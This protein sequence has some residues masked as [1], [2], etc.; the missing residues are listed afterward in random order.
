[1]T[2]SDPQGL[3]TI[4]IRV[5]D[6]AGNTTTTTNHSVYIDTIAPAAP[7]FVDAVTLTNQNTYTL[8]VSGEP[9]SILRIHNQENQLNQVN[10]GSDVLG[11]D[12]RLVVELNL[13][14]GQ[15]D[16][17]ATL[18]DEVG[19]VSSA[20]MLS[21]VVDQTPPVVGGLSEVLRYVSTGNVAV[22]FT[23]IDPPPT[24]SQ[25]G[26]TVLLPGAVAP[27]PTGM[28][29]AIA[30]S[31][32]FNNQPMTAVAVEGGVYTYS[33]AVTNSDIQG[34]AS[35]KI[36]ATDAA[37]NT[38]TTT[39]RSVFIDTIAPVAPVVE[40]PLLLTND[41]QYSVGITA[42]IGTK[43]EVFH[44]GVLKQTMSQLL[45]SIPVNFLFNE[46][47]QSVSFRS[48]DTAGNY[49]EILAYDVSVDLTTIQVVGVSLNHVGVV[50][51][52]SY[53]VEIVFSEDV[54]TSRIPELQIRSASDRGIVAEIFGYGDR[55][56][57]LT[58]HYEAGDDGVS[59]L[60]LS[61]VY[62]KAGNSLPRFDYEIYR[63]D[64]ISPTAPVFVDAVTFTNQNVY[65]LHV[66]GEAGSVLTLTGATGG[67]APEILY[68]SLQAT[69]QQ[70][71]VL[72]LPEGVHDLSAT[73]TD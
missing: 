60:T 16:L 53:G 11:A 32:K 35:I 52:N 8:S 31:L 48:V 30:L 33:Y 34:L 23:V 40:S 4:E 50:S 70:S 14:E 45:A 2:N 19:N 26:E 39:N 66:S 58:V 5:T 64:S 55:K 9:G 41:S 63:V 6:A 24:P 28:E 10:P 37:G 22:S 38:S 21:V 47:S 56:L 43:L 59:R 42:E 29:R 71:V 54:D 3:A 62:D 27:D 46:G 69:A 72:N 67:G 25:E 1:V 20:S 51:A 49:S 36:T 12:G 18:T 13:A 17:S 44:N 68:R 61:D 65:T 57:S 15:H 7:V 73:L